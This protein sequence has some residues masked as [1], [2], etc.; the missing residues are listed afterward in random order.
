VAWVPTGMKIGVSMTPWRV[1]SRARRAAQSV[2][3]PS[4]WKWGWLEASGETGF[5][6][7]FR[8]MD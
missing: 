1:R 2:A 7:R 8:R 6:W 3:V 4:S 5:T